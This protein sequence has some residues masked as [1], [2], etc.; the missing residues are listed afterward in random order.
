M[1]NIAN[2]TELNWLLSRF[3][4]MFKLIRADSAQ[5]S[6]LV[7]VGRWPVSFAPPF[8]PSRQDVEILSFKTP[9][10]FRRDSVE[11]PSRFRR[12]S[13][14]FPSRFPRDSLEI[15]S[16]FPRDSLEI[17]SRFPWDSVEILFPPL[18]EDVETKPS[19]LLSFKILMTVNECYWT[20][21]K[22]V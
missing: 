17:P 13:V 4:L 9:S 2:L 3:V 14:E 7:R 10:R 16:I 6:M 22:N 11:I 18:R 19:Y 8:P 20:T 12:D 5:W 15:P 1:I 21:K